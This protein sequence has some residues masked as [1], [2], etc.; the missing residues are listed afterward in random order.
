MHARGCN[1]AICLSLMLSGCAISL[2]PIAVNQE[3]QAKIFEKVATTIV[4]IPG[5]FIGEIGYSPSLFSHL[6]A[7]ANGK[8][9]VERYEI[10]DPATSVAEAIAK[11]L[12]EKFRIKSAGLSSKSP[13]SD[14]LHDLVASA[15]DTE[16]IVG[17]RTI[18][19]GFNPFVTMSQGGGYRVVY[20]VR[21]RV[22]DAKRQQVLAQG[23][24]DSV[25]RKKPGIMELDHLTNNDAEL[26]KRELK[27]E[28]EFC[29]NE[30]Q[31]QILP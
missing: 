1:L 12:S 26:L 28:A 15:P 21:L 23:Y 16:I 7:K 19:W 14:E 29:S 22:V 25:T 17:V 31:K 4:A 27:D 20:R 9:I 8:E 24:C 30:L 5:P 13:E 18:D 6:V 11:L 3:S 10:K 2:P